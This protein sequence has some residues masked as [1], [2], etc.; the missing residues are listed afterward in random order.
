METLTQDTTMVKF[1]SKKLARDLHKISYLGGI[2]TSNKIEKSLKYGV[3][4]YILYLAPFK[5]AGLTAT[6]KQINTCAK[7]TKW[8]IDGCLNTSGQARLGDHVNLARIKRTQLFY[9]DR[10]YFMDWIVAEINTAQKKAERDGNKFS[11]RING[12]SDLSPEIFKVNGKNLLELYPTV[13]F[14]DYTK[15][16]NRVDLLAKYSNYHLTFS[17]SGNNWND[18]ETFLQ[19]GG[20]VAMVFN[21]RKGKDL[22][23]TYKGYKV[24]DG[25]LHDYRPIDGKGVIVGLR[26]KEIKD[27][28]ANK[29]IKTESPFVV[30]VS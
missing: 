20:N 1:S 21:V 17:Y 15:V 2:A 14:Y 8:C 22:P 13:Q 23:E 30:Q 25:D 16:A 11:V 26:W 9:N 24:V 28:K 6:G 5:S 27:R 3:S 18:C 10:N 12:T 19:T 7:A 4:T 29:E